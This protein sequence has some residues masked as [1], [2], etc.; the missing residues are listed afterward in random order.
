MNKCEETIRIINKMIG[1]CEPIKYCDLN[2]CFKEKE[3]GLL[4]KVESEDNVIG[5][6][7]IDSSSNGYCISTLSLI[8]TITDILVGKR[9][10]FTVDGEYVTGVQWYYE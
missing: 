9:L 4:E 3:I 10:A 8:A 7:P 1:S 2:N 5:I 6:R